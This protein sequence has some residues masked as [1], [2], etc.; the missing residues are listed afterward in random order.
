[1]SHRPLHRVALVASGSTFRTYD[2]DTRGYLRDHALAGRCLLPVV[3]VLDWMVTSARAQLGPAATLRDLRVF[4]GVPLDAFHAGGDRLELRTD[5]HPDGDR[6]L[7][8]HRAGAPLPAFRAI[9]G[10]GA[11]PVPRELPWPLDHFP[12]PIGRVY[13]E[14]LFHGPRFQVLRAIA[15]IS[16][17]GMVAEVDGVLSMGWASPAGWAT[18]PAALDGALQLAAL[19]TRT[20]TGRAALPTGVALARFVSGPPIGPIRLVLVGRSL[21]PYGS[22]VDVTLE[23]RSGAVFA[24]L[25]GVQ[26]HVLPDGH[27][28]G[29]DAAR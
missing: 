8:L 23:D 5:A 17:R 27:Y 10:V 25:R 6:V 9:A 3:E 26:M 29:T 28:P 16:P 2:A 7:S 21:T 18:D 1:M 14:L 12:T 19:W 4:R 20:H 15:G 22:T 11:P 13:D 24:E